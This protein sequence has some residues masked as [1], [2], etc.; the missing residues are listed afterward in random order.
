MNY[1]TMVIEE[2]QDIL[3]PAKSH[4]SPKILEMNEVEAIFD[5]EDSSLGRL[6]SS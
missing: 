1:I 5:K 3:D 6:K 4:L 2:L